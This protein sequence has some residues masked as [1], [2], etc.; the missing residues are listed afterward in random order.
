MFQN[1]YLSLSIRNPLKS[2]NVISSVFIIFIEVIY[3][4]TFWSGTYFL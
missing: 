2:I 3:I 4:T 1:L